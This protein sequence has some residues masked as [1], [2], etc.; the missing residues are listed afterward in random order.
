MIVTLSTLLMPNTI[1]RQALKPAQTKTSTTVARNLG[2]HKSLKHMKS[3]MQDRCG[4]A[5]SAI[6]IQKAM[7]NTL[8]INT[9]G[10]NMIGGTCTSALL[11][12]VPLM[13]THMVMMNSTLY[14]GICRRTMA[15]SPP[16]VV[17]N[18][19]GPSAVSKHSKN[20]PNCPGKKDKFGPKQTPYAEKRFKCDQCAKKYTTQAALL[21]HMKVHKGTN[22]KYVCSLCG[23]ALSSTTALHKHEK[24]HQSN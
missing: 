14:G 19:M 9:T 10:P 2:P 13:G 21:Q 11:P 3:S 23:K 1:P 6:K 12:P 7:T 22:K 4:H 17:P 16:W 5:L 8:F 18:V 15:C 24:I 20:I